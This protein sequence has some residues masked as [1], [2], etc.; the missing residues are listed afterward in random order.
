MTRPVFELAERYMEQRLALD[1][2]GATFLGAPGYDDQCT[3]LSPA[4]AEERAAVDRELLVELAGLPEHTD[5]V[6]RIAAEVIKE[7]IE[8]RL[9]SFETGEHLR[10]IGVLWSSAHLPRMV[11]DLMPRES[12]EHWANIASRLEGVGPALAGERESLDAGIAQGLFAARRQALGV[13]RTFRVWAGLES[14]GGSAGSWFANLVAEYPGGELGDRLQ[15][16]AASAT[17][18]YADFAAYLERDYAPAAPVHDGVGEQRYATLARY[19]T[20]SD[21]D[22]RETYAWGWAEAQRLAGEIRAVC[23]AIRPG[24]SVAEVLESLETDPAYRIDGAENLISHLQDLT[25]R[26]IAE[27][28][29]T[30]FDIP[31]VMRKCE[32][33]IAP[34]GGAAAPYYN[35]PS[36]DFS[37]PGTTWYPT[38]GET[39][40]STWRLPTIW[41]HEAV[42]GHHLQVAY[43]VYRADRLSRI[44]RTEFVSGHGEGWALY[45]E[46]L[47]A[48]LG[49]YADPAHLLGHLGAQQWR[50]VRIVL[51]IGLHLDLP[52]PE[53]PR[54][55]GAPE[56]GSPWTRDEAVT[57]LRTQALLGDAMAASEVDRY[58]GLPGQAISYKVGERVWLECRESARQR[59]GDAFD[60]KAWHKFALELGS[61]GLD[62]LRAELA[63]F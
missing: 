48:E 8:S 38:L 40:F 17:A 60:L 43:A 13:A 34:P 28:A 52:V 53:G 1:P 47:M 55:D 30:Y 26:T 4:G 35:G 18:A 42:P 9:I 37:R 36:E 27:F 29:G 50:A 7:R 24:A 10:D 57:F 61:M 16:G 41:F 49:Y 20:G 32:A 63:R 54:L 12:E 2:Y 5:D 23:E 39:T 14:E 58:L 15:S 45:A 3:D 21:L 59:H 44:Q 6:E 19:W 25:D 51:D 56:P 46:R 22:L 31:D 11:F 62:P 33:R